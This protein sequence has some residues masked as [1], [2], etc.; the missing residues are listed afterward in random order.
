MFTARHRL[1][2]PNLPRLHNP[3]LQQ[4]LQQRI[5]QKTKPPGSLGQLEALALQLGL[6]LNTATPAIQQP[7][8]RVFAADHGLTDEGIS[9][10]PKAVTQQMVLNFLAGG[11]AINVFARQH[12]LTLKV[13]DAGVDADFAPHPDL[14]QKKVMRGT[15]NSLQT[16]AMNAEECLQAVFCGMAL[17][18]EAPGNL[19]VVGEMGIGNTSAA[20]LLLSKLG[21]LPLDQCIGRGTGLDDAGLAHKQA[22]LEQVLHKHRQVKNPLEILATLGGLE[23]AM[24]TGALLQAASERR[25][26]LMDGFIACSAL[27]VA[28]HLQPGIKDFAVFSHASAEPGHRHLLQLLNASPL[29]DLDLRLGEGTGAVLAYPLLQSALA[30]LND[31][32]SFTDA[33]VSEKMP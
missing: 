5:D 4:Q 10:F 6:I 3:T 24:M 16:A 19:L 7:Q 25:I 14:L 12:G 9:A 18:R 15:R 28:E 30:F 8:I 21:K 20:S 32:A 26:L 22:I 31:M 29:L 2:L 17:V 1:E 23:I 27:L 11:A 13:V 33:G